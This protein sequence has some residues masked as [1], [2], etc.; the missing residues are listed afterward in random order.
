MNIFLKCPADAS[1]ILKK[2]LYCASLIMTYV[3]CV[4]DTSEDRS[5]KIEEYF[6]VYDALKSPPTILTITSIMHKLSWTASSV[7]I[8]VPIV[9]AIEKKNIFGLQYS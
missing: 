6:N 8:E 5:L 1:S 7:H 9:L 4:L 3:K 2:T